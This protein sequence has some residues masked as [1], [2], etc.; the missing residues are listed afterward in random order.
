MAVTI[1]TDSYGDEAGLQAYADARGVTVAGDKTQLLY[2]A[3]DWLEIQPYLGVKYNYSQPLQHPRTPTL[4]DVTAGTVD[5][6]IIKAQYVAALLIDAGQDLNPVVKP[7]RKRVGAG[8]NAIEVEYQPYANDRNTYP[9][10]QSLL[11]R[12]LAGLQVRRV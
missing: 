11:R 3:M 7:A 1:G 8:R 9:E 12:H 4:Y 6:D 2:K 10:L 5:P